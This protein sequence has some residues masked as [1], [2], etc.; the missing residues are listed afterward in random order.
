MDSTCWACRYRA[1]TKTEMTMGVTTFSATLVA[2]SGLQA[3]GRYPG[4]SQQA[5]QPP[6]AWSSSYY[7]TS[8]SSAPC[9]N[10]ACRVPPPGS[11]L[12]WRLPLSPCHAPQPYSPITGALPSG[13]IGG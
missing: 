9:S 5:P 11:L 12:G 6:Q 2:C 3:G 7:S 8:L 1:S 13:H 4:T 10:C